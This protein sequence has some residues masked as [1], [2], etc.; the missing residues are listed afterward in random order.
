MS[1]A[2]PF[3]IE[4]YTIIMCL[5]LQIRFDQ[6]EVFGKLARE[7]FEQRLVR[8]VGAVYAPFAER[9]GA[10]GCARFV[11]RNIQRAIGHGIDTNGAITSFVEICVEFG[12][13]FELSPDGSQAMEHLSDPEL[14]GQIKIALIIEA[15]AE[16]T[17][18]RPVCEVS[19]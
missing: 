11:H 12:E 13:Q 19:S 7:Q 17:G 4:K 2:F 14:P 18:G 15:L 1:C 8:H 9:L 5:M 16:R 10:E 3:C 6:M